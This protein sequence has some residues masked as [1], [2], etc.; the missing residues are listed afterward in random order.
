[1]L[2]FR[3]GNFGNNVKYAR[4]NEIMEKVQQNRHISRSLMF[5]YHMI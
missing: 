3:Y 1:M 4:L 5:G 2:D